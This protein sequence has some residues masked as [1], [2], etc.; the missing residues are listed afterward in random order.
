MNHKKLLQNIATIGA[1]V[2][3]FAVGIE[4][5]RRADKSLRQK[6]ILVSGICNDIRPAGNHVTIRYNFVTQKKRYHKDRFAIR[7]ETASFRELRSLIVGKRFPVIYDSTRFR[8]S[9]M[10]IFREDFLKFDCVIPDSL[11][12]LVAHIDSI[13]HRQPVSL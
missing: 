8:N 2:L 5:D 4:C 3:I 6:K 7:Q 12:S 11:A 9:R 1:F 13:R 10:L